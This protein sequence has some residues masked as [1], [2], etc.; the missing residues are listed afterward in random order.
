MA[1]YKP[2]HPEPRKPSKMPPPMTCDSQF[3][4]LGDPETYPTRPG[5]AYHMPSATWERALHMHRQLGIE[6]GVIVQTTT[7]GAD[8][9]VVLDGLAAMG[10]NYKGCAN[11]LVFAEKDDAYLETMNAAGIN[12]ARFSFRQALGAVLDD[13]AFDAAVGKLRDLGWYMKVQPEQTGIA[14]SVGKLDGV[15]IPVLIDHMGRP[16]A[17][18]GADDVNI[19]ALKKLLDRGNFWVMLSLGEKI[20]KTGAPWDDVVPLAQALIEHAPERCVWASDWPHPVSPKQPPN[21]AELL[22]LFYRYAP[23]EAVQNQ[24]LVDNPAKLF[25]F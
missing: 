8:H 7:Y 12:G 14:D 1:D 16:D 15:D 5:A 4:V 24:I 2:F 22:E 21:D 23:D 17:S 13:A 3:H 20:S 6:R 19:T 10:P 9:S 25:G 11:A 18:K